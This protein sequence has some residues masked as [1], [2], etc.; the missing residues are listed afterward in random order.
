MQGLI[1]HDL[2]GIS[3]FF[4]SII[5]HA[6]AAHKHAVGIDGVGR[7]GHQGAVVLALHDRK[8]IGLLGQNDLDLV[9]LIGQH[10]VHDVQVKFVALL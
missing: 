8:V 6:G 9:H 1:L 5:G 3:G 10:L 2:R 7:A 4:L